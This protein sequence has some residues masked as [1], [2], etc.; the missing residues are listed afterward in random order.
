MLL[1]S[2]QITLIVYNKRRRGKLIFY[3]TQVKKEKGGCLD[4][5]QLS[6]PVL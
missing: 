5:Y 1:P 3:Q 6:Y 4:R 2:T